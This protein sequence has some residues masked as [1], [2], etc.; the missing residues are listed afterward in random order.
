MGHGRMGIMHA[1]TVWLVQVVGGSCEWGFRFG[2]GSGL[3]KS[4]GM[5]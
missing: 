2:G 1:I 5:I 4:N 3:K